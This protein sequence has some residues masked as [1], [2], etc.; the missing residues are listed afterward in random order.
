MPKI[1][2]VPSPTERVEK[3]NRSSGDTAKT[4]NEKNEK[5][6]FKNPGLDSG[7]GIDQNS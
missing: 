2:E 6:Q 3:L 1:I 4:K 7:K 5:K